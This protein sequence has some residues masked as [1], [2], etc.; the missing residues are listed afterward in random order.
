[1]GLFQGLSIGSETVPLLGA[2]ATLLGALVGAG[3]SIA[4]TYWLHNKQLEAEEQRLRK[5]LIA[6]VD[7][8]ETS[9]LVRIAEQLQRLGSR[10]ERQDAVQKEVRRMFKNAGDEDALD[11]IPD[12][13]MEGIFDWAAHKFAEG[14][15]KTLNELSTIDL[16]TEVYD[17]NLD[18]I[19]RLDVSDI[20]EIIEYYKQIHKL[21]QTVDSIIQALES[22][23]QDTDVSQFGGRLKGQANGLN[24]QKTRVLEILR[25][26]ENESVIGRLR[27][28]WTAASERSRDFVRDRATKVDILTLFLLPS[29]FLFAVFLY[30]ESEQILEY[31]ARNP[32]LLGII[33]SA[34][35]HRNWPHLLG[36]LLGL[37]L[38]G[39]TGYVLTRKAGQRNLYR[40]S[41]VSYL[42]VLPFFA[43][44]F[45]RRMLSNQPDI[46]S[47]LESVGFSII[48]GSL[49]A[50]LTISI[51]VY[52]KWMSDESRVIVLSAC[53][54]LGGFGVVFYQ[55]DFPL[56]VTVLTVAIGVSVC[57]YALYRASDGSDD[58]LWNI[59]YIWFIWALVLLIWSVMILF[60][61]S[62]G[63]GYFGHMAGYW[64]GFIIPIVG[65]LVLRVVSCPP[66]AAIV[67][68]LFSRT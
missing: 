20:E 48:V 49:A 34:F 60:S 1:M 57:I 7:S 14:P 28:L 10:D 68:R 50:F 5:A 56:G 27:N 40:A 13:D 15:T 6:E 12:E 43:N 23:E 19:G 35:A 3:A 33:G 62:V 59:E 61:P 16:S 9:A 11:N 63:G 67:S 4:S 21:Q 36:N 52:L 53:L 17:A 65:I 44:Y 22:G 54:F 26:D 58:S 55:M 31:K 2:I 32:S 18:K 42:V 38:V 29:I 8:M 66:L 47:Q 30:P 37:W 24:A 46:L 45:I 64:G 41:F 39:G 25:D 51:P